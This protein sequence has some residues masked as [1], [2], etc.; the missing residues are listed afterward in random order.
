MGNE[1]KVMIRGIYSTALTKLL[2]EEGLL[3]VRPSLEILR[4]FG[5][6]FKFSPADVVIT[7]RE[8]LQGVY[9]KG[10][11]DQTDRVVSILKKALPD[12]VVRERLPLSQGVE[13]G[14]RI[15]LYSSYAFYDVEFPL[16]SKR[17]LDGLRSRVVT[18]LKD[19]H[20]LKTIDPDK[21][22][23]AEAE[24]ARCPEKL[25]ELSSVLK[26]QLIQGLH[27]LGRLIF[28]DHVKLNGTVIHLSGGKV[29]SVGKN[30]LSIKRMMRGGS[31]YDGLGEPKEE[32]DYAITE[33]VEGSWILK[34]S[35]FSRDGELKGEFYNINTP[36]ELY[37]GKIRYIDLEID[38]VRK[39]GEKLRIIDSD[40]LEEA[41]NEGYVSEKLANEALKRAKGLVEKTPPL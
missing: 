26:N 33:C 9:V 13:S 27:K 6:R 24:L 40:K 38:V 5:P 16:G 2:L 34:H 7:D 17:F 25:E 14:G 20:H 10:N 19:H 1:V 28:I 41:L 23:E 3:V 35:Y 30:A 12:V 31:R 39:P 8:D 11:S 15:E 37:P 4:R 32:G 22:N 18:T 29:V 21:V 36:I